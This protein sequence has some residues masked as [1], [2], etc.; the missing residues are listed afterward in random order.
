[1]KF[2]TIFRSR[3]TYYQLCTT[4]G[5]QLNVIETSFKRNLGRFIYRFAGFEI[6]RFGVRTSSQDPPQEPLR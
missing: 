3:S 1:M 5:A 6:L 4:F 2:Y